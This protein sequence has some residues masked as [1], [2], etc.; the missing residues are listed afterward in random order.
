M[1]KKALRN[2]DGSIC[3]DQNGNIILVDVGSS[4]A[5]G[6]VTNGVAIEQASHVFVM[7]Q[8][9]EGG[10]LVDVSTF[11]TPEYMASMGSMGIMAIFGQNI[12]YNGYATS[13]VY[14]ADT[15]MTPLYFIGQSGSV[16][17]SGATFTNVSGLENLRTF[18]PQGA[19]PQS[20]YLGVLSGIADFYKYIGS[21][22]TLNYTNLNAITADTGL[23]MYD[24]SRIGST[25]YYPLYTLMDSTFASVASITPDSAV[26]Q[27]WQEA[28][29][30]DLMS[31][32]SEHDPMSM[33]AN[34]NGAFGPSQFTLNVP[35]LAWVEYCLIYASSNGVGTAS[36]RA[37]AS[38]S[39]YFGSDIGYIGR[40]IMDGLASEDTID[41]YIPRTDYVPELHSGGSSNIN[42]YVPAAM[43]TAYQS[44]NEWSNCNIQPYTF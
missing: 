35:S 7:K 14:P 32:L 43:V 15:T 4:P 23:I 16:T 42:V 24:C 18:A 44:A 13:G 34:P 41:V 25:A 17:I 31:W 11:F 12:T 30:I 29:G 36:G 22:V 1:A 21:N 38:G 26:C 39:I 19:F 2:K 28:L 20:D 9:V 8:D 5:P 6:G 27:W 3:V 37:P 10:E 40:G 33:L